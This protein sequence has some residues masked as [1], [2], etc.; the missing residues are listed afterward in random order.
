MNKAIALANKARIQQETKQSWLNNNR[1]CGCMGMPTE[2]PVCSEECYY[3]YMD[4]IG[5]FNEN[6]ITPITPPPNRDMSDKNHE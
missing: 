2:P 1:D 6:I 3:K 4:K 5:A